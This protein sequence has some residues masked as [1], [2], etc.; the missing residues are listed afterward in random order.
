MFI[1]IK[2]KISTNWQFFIVSVL[3]SAILS[4]IFPASF[5]QFLKIFY[6]LLLNIL[7]VF[8]LVF[9]FIFIFDLFLTPKRIIKILGKKSGF[10]GWVLAILLGIM[11][12]GPVY[13]W[14]PLVD[15]LRD[16]GMRDSLAIAF[17]YNR[18]IKIPLMPMIIFYFGLPFLIIMSVLMILF[19]VINGYVGEILLIKFGEKNEN[20]SS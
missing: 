15:E 13:M 5:G 14:Y 9:A 17:L 6:N 2:E 3:I 12:S 16:E 1:K 8:A 20:R 19:S 11:S 10:R 4:I 18:A 7:P